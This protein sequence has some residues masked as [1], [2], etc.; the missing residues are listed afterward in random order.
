MKIPSDYLLGARTIPKALTMAGSDSG[1]GA[2]IQADLKTF[3]ALGVHGMSALTSVT[4]QNTLGVT[5]IQDLSPEIVKAQI[6]AVAEDIG[7]DAAKTG[8][9]HT[10][11]IIEAIAE[12]IKKYSFPTVV[13]PVM[14]AKSGAVL[15]QPD[16]IETLKNRLLPLARVVTPNAPEAEAL[17]GLKVRSYD[18]AVAAAKKISSL[19]PQA[20]VVKG[21]HIQGSSAVDVLYIDGIVKRFEAE[22]VSSDATH[23][24]GCSFSAAIAAEIAKG[25]EIVEA[26]ASAKRLVSDAIRFGLKLG[27][28]HGPVN[29]LAP[30]Y[31]EAERYWV[32]RNISEALKTLETDPNFYRLIPESQTNLVMALSFPTGYDDV[33]AIPGRIVRIGKWAYAS[34]PPQFG[35]SKHVAATVL[36]AQRFETTVRAGMNIRFSEEILRVCERLKLTVSSYDRTREPPEVKSTEG[37]STIWGAE[38]AIKAIGRVP[39]IIFHR[40]DWGKEPMITILAPTATEAT[41]IAQNI[42]AEYAKAE[43]KNEH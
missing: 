3:A 10:S 8:M 24:T 11:E 21:G 19:G 43:S 13:D 7:V 2:G 33:A 14:V 4:A 15:L 17:S 1:G 40:G 41:K 5:V 20:V 27:K 12:E 42:A 26:V 18:D 22:R 32:T 37:R 39:D 9:L 25:R 35:V 28:G 29:P 38:E 30:L 34:A 31:R 6:E 16:A 23:G 36:V